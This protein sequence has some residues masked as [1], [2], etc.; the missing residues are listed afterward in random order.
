MMLFKVSLTE[1]P[2]QNALV[3]HLFSEYL[4][5]PYP[6]LGISGKAN[7]ATTNLFSGIDFDERREVD[8]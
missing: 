2:Q 1:K 3:I 6:V 4:L 8:D 7:K 5:S